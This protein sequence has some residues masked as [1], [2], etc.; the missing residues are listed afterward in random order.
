MT[1]L[2]KK[3]IRLHDSGYRVFV[4]V[5]GIDFRVSGVLTPKGSNGTQDQDDIVIAPITAVQDTLRVFSGL[6][7]N[8]ATLQS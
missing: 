7:I 5:N 8:C 3:R 4:A 1:G 2:S 6:T